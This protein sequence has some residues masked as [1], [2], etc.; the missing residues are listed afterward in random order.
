MGVDEQAVAAPWLLRGGSLFVCEDGA[1]ALGR[2]V[3]EEA[4]GGR[5][6]WCRGEGGR[7]PSVDLIPERCPRVEERWGE[8]AAAAAAK[9]LVVGE[10]QPARES[11]D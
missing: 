2:R 8:E 6:R 4:A 10:S 7:R 11:E 1:A 3:V 5:L 9:L